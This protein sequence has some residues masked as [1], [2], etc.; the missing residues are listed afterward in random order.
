MVGSTRESD[1]KKDDNCRFG[2]MRP[3]WI[4]RDVEVENIFRI[5][6]S[7]HD[8]LSLNFKILFYLLFIIE[9]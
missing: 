4:Q 2:D 9:T 3:T 5:G 1:G 8:A 6:L 7:M